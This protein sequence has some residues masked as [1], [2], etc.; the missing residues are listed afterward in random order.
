[1]A[2]I[3]RHTNYDHIAQTE[4]YNYVGIKSDLPIDKS[5]IAI[6]DFTFISGEPYREI[7]YEN[8]TSA[9]YTFY[10]GEAITY[11]GRYGKFLL[12]YR[13]K[14]GPWKGIEGY[15]ELFI[16][17]MYSRAQPILLTVTSSGSGRVLEMTWDDSLKGRKSK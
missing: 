4:E 9:G 3:W 14:V 12:F 2:T 6:G 15:F 11:V 1:M 17:F 5:E 16:A 8:K 10:R 13:T 7:G